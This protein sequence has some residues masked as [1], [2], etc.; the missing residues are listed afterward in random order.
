MNKEEENR[1]IKY[2]FIELA[3]QHKAICKDPKCTI[4]LSSLIF[5]SKRLGIK[6][7]DKEKV[8]MI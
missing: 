7:T 4:N 2:N 1:W 8:N 3:K 5:A 6:L